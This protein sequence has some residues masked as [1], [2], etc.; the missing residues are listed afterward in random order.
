[1]AVPPFAWGED[2][3]GG[4]VEGGEQGRGPVADVVVGDPLQIAEPQGEERLGAV[5]GLDLALLIHAQHHRLIG[6]VEV[7]ADDIAHFLHEEGVGGELE[8]LL[9]MRLEPERLPDPLHRGLGKLGLRGDRAAGP[10][11]R[12]FGFGVDRLAD[13]LGDLFVLDRAGPARPQLVV[14]PGD[15]LLEVALAPQPHGGAREAQRPSDGGV[16]LPLSGEQD[17]LGAHDEGVGQGSRAGHRVE[18]VALVG[19]EAERVQRSTFG[20][21]APSFSLRRE[22]SEGPLSSQATPGT[23]H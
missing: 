22:S 16:A 8:V 21:G 20:H 9:P 13:E 14:E 6:W 23:Q 3:A 5:E 11:G 4:D 17:D 2:L 10:V 7:E 15:P 18:D 1:V 12:V 19:R